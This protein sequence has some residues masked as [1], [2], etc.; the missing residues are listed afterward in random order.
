MDSDCVY[1]HLRKSG[2]KNYNSATWYLPIQ[3]RDDDLNVAGD[4]RKERQKIFKN[5]IN[6]FE[7][8][9]DRNEYVG[10]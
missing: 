10:Y 7:I 3:L 1:Y 6:I 9:W 4:T 2:I 8:K 5:T